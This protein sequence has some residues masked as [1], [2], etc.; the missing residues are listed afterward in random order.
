MEINDIKSKKIF[1]KEFKTVET[2]PI[3]P[4]NFELSDFI[5]M[6]DR[7]YK[8]VKE[9]KGDRHHITWDIFSKELSKLFEAKVDLIKS[10][11]TLSIRYKYLY[12][13]WLN[14]CE[15]LD[16]LAKPKRSLYDNKIKKMRDKSKIIKQ[17]VLGNIDPSEYSPTLKTKGTKK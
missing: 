16:I 5:E 7:H 2:M 6:I 17:I 12:V 3:N 14:K 9:S 1:G 10:N 13:Y 8:F 15:L 11:R 4:A